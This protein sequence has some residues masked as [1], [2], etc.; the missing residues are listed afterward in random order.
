MNTEFNNQDKSKNIIR[1][2][3][4][5]NSVTVKSH[6]IQILLVVM[7]V[8][9]LFGTF[10]YTSIEGWSF[11]DSLYMTVITLASIGYQ[12]VHPL[13]QEGRIFTI[14]L[15]FVGFGFVTVFFSAV[16]QVILRVQ[17]W[18]ISES[19]RRLDTIKRLRNHTI[20]CG[21]GRLS[22]IAA[23]ELLRNKIELVI[24]EHSPER[25]EDARS[26]GFLVVEGDA[27]LDETLLL[28]GIKH[29]NRLVSLLSKGSDNLYV[30]LT[31][32]ELC[33]NLFIMSRAEDET[34]EKRLKRA[35]V[36]R[37]IS[38]YRV[39][40]QKIADGLIRPYVTNFLDLAASNNTANLQI[41]E[42]KIPDDS[43]L[44]GFTLGK[45]NIRRFS[46][47]IVAA[48]IPVEGPMVFNPSANATIDPGSTFIVLGEKDELRKFEN[49][50]FGEKSL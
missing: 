42:V 4:W 24:I 18:R 8:L 6:E 2:P 5:S 7:I 26:Q 38:P 11:F 49:I 45:A 43:P 27:T 31:S 46:N 23:L 34:F 35:G 33:P 15:I 3:I 14:L 32:K 20:I 22:Q 44:S 19:K 21:F 1:T 50:L 39:G 36:T 40:G 13:S 48:I 25:A 9:I 16:T 10:G 17:L 30:V 29:A 28:A 41:E 47:I 12:E 37:L